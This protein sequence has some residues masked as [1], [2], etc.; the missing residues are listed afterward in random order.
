MDNEYRLRDLPFP[1]ISRIRG[2]SAALQVLER[3]KQSPLHIDM[4][5]VD[6]LSM[7]FMDELVFHLAASANM[8]NVVFIIDDQVLLNKLAH[9]ADIRQININYKF[10][11]EQIKRLEHKHFTPSGV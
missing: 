2:K 6:M 7:S 3:V 5:D 11:D 9:I 10:A 4:R 8:R 1:C